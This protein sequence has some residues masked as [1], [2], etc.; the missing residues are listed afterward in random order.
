MS[1]AVKKVKKQAT[2]L[3]FFHILLG[4]YLLKS[5]LN[6]MGCMG[7]KSVWVTWVAWVYKILVWVKKNGMG[8][9]GPLNCFIEKIIKNF[10]KFTG[11]RLC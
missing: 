11:K 10:A 8:G 9:M 4:D 2:S 7:P 3:G 1:N 5:L 6:Y